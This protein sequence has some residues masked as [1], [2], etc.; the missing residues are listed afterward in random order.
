[1]RAMSP[2]IIVQSKTFEDVNNYT[3]SDTNVLARRCEGGGGRGFTKVLFN[4]LC[5]GKWGGG[6]G[7]GERSGDLK[8]IRKRC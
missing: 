1:M 3:N 5:G 2:A 6:K 4:G 7:G 8:P